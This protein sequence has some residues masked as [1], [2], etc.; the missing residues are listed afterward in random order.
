MTPSV[1][2]VTVR[3]IH[4]HGRVHTFIVEVRCPF[5]GRTHSHGWPPGEPTIGTRRAHCGLGHY[6]ITEPRVVA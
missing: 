2:A 1:D 6:R 5:C 4:R 3:P